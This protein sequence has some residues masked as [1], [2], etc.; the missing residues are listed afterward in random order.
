MI[1]VTFSVGKW[2]AVTPATLDVTSPTLFRKIYSLFVVTILTVLMIYAIINKHFYRDFM[3]VKSAVCLLTDINLFIFNVV[4]VMSVVFWKN[5]QWKHL[6][7]NLKLIEANA[8]KKST[9]ICKFVTLHILVFTTII[10]SNCFWVKIHGFTFVKQYEILYF[11]IYLQCFYCLL[12]SEILT[13]IL[14]SYRHLFHVLSDAKMMSPPK[15][16]SDFYT[17]KDTVNVFNDIFGWPI[18]LLISYTIFKVLIFLDHALIMSYLYK[19]DEV[20]VILLLD[21]L[22]I[23][24]TFVSRCSIRLNL[25]IVCLQGSPVLLILM[26]DA[27]SNESRKILELSRKLKWELDSNTSELSK[28]TDFVQEHLPVFSA[29]RFFT[30]DRGTILSVLGSVTSFFIVMIQFRLVVHNIT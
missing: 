2:L 12:L 10:G 20:L 22:T 5:Q 29:A 3:Q 9:R 27:V 25:Y 30:I 14:A 18:A 26:C 15:I 19:N 21:G 7:N 13:P 1:K 8:E 28:L 11:Q 23:A 6:T 17:L 4:T 16:R 24:V